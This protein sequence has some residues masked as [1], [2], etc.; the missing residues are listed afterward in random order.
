MLK[1]AILGDAGWDKL[2]L[3]DNAMVLMMGTKDEDMPAQPVE[4][5]KFVEDMDEREL[6]GHVLVLGAHHQHHQPVLH[7]HLVPGLIKDGP[8][9]HHLLPLRLN[10]SQGKQLGLEDHGLLVSIDLHVLVDLLAPF[11]L[12]LVAWHGWYTKFHCHCVLRFKV[13]IIS[14]RS[15]SS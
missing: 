7:L 12:D 3:R 1:G 9:Q 15:E 5:T 13:T 6:G 11:Y 10:P 8:L 4:K 14:C 2:K